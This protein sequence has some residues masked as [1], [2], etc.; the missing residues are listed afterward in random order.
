M[1]VSTVPRTQIVGNDVARKGGQ[2]SGTELTRWL[3][4]AI[5]GTNPGMR[6]RKARPADDKLDEAVLVMPWPTSSRSPIC[7]QRR[8]DA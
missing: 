5:P 8:K 1:R 4:A 6:I 3:P 2:R 7:V